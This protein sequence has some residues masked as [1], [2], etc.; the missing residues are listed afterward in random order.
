M[1]FVSAHQDGLGQKGLCRAPGSKPPFPLGSL[2]WPHAAR[3]RGDQHGHQHWCNWSFASLVL[4]VN[5]PTSNQKKIFQLLPLPN[6]NNFT[7]LETSECTFK[8]SRGFYCVFSRC[9]WPISRVSTH[10]RAGTAAPLL[11]PFATAFKALRF[12]AQLVS[13][14]LTIFKHLWNEVVSSKPFKVLGKKLSDWWY[15]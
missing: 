4:P 6:S 8:K 5:N 11:H 12:H 9:H 15:L 14:S 3:E 7:T 1:E 13:N 10:T 2:Q